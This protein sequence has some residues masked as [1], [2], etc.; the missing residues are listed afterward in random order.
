[1]LSQPCMVCNRWVYVPVSLSLKPFSVY[2]LPEQ[3]VALIVLSLT[4]LTVKFNVTVLS[5]PCMVCNRWVYVPVSLSL[6][7]FSV[8]VLPE[9][10][11]ALIVLSLTG[12][13]VKFRVILRQPLLVCM[14]SIYIP[15]S[16]ILKPFSVYVVPSQIVA[17]IVVSIIGFTVKFKVTMLSQPCMV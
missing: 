14:V 3:I 4:G 11:V 8:Y 15:V 9:Q 6:K 13:T 16:L 7:P 1:M 10:I 5:Q 17:L 2:V 12:L